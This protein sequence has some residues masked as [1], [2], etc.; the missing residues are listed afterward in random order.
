MEDDELDG[1][2][3]MAV[4]PPPKP[5][6]VPDM[7]QSSL[8]PPIGLARTL[9]DTSL[10]A[11]FDKAPPVIEP[12]NR[13]ARILV[14][15]ATGHDILGR[16]YHIAQHEA[17]KA[18]QEQ[19]RLNAQIEE[20]RQEQ[21]Q[22]NFWKK[23]EFAKYMLSR[24]ESLG[25]D[26]D[27]AT[28]TYFKAMDDW[29]RANTEAEGFR[30]AQ[31][32]SPGKEK[33]AAIKYEALQVAMKQVQRVQDERDA[34][35]KMLPAMI[36]NL[37]PPSMAGKKGAKL[38]Q[39]GEAPQSATG[40]PSA[41]PGQEDAQMGPMLP[42]TIQ[43]RTIQDFATAGG[44]PDW[45][46]PKN[47]PNVVNG[48]VHY[49]ARNAEEKRAMDERGKAISAAKS[50]P[51][52]FVVEDRSIRLENS[53]KAY[54]W[55]AT[56]ARME[57]AKGDFWRN[58]EQTNPKTA[59]LQNMLAA[60]GPNDERAGVLA[61]LINMTEAQRK[62]KMREL[63]KGHED[64]VLQYQRDMATLRP[65]VEQWNRDQ[66]GQAGVNI[67][68]EKAAES[69]FELGS[70]PPPGMTDTEFKDYYIALKNQEIMHYG[71]PGQNKWN[72]AKPED[73]QRQDL[74]DA[75]KKYRAGQ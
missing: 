23:T 45:N 2:Q 64:N 20:H 70:A 50:I 24:Q 15:G 5:Q 47:P 12:P 49:E 28:Q 60:A 57:T 62:V 14:A 68:P 35:H 9:A 16:N 54:Q 25:H 56:Q 26:Y 39:G 38:G 67:V 48:M 75:L 69:T 71:R 51:Y 4:A 63:A 74:Q 17:I 41:A 73:W 43:Q 37:T 13:L 6:E 58:L 34:M 31:I 33:E 21:E 22:Q 46:D 27:A 1:S 10:G 29:S 18:F 52:P 19:Q 8:E 65:N 59:E 42:Q 61:G 7:G 44:F 11:N 40:E 55:N 36:A 72:P 66:M 32:P 3:Q 53:L 30:A